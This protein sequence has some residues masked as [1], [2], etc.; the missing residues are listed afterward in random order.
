MS[1][2]REIEMRCRRSQAPALFGLVA[3]IF[4][5]AAVISWPTKGLCQ[6]A[7]G[8]SEASEA[9]AAQIPAADRNYILGPSDVLEVDVLGRADFKTRA[10]IGEDGTIQLPYLGAVV[11]AN[12]TTTQLADDISAALEKGGFFSHPILSIEIVSYASRYVTVLGEVER[13]GLIPVDR[14]YRLSEILARVGGVKDDGADYVVMRPDNGPPRHLSISALATGDPTQD[15][16]VSPGDKIFSPKAEVFYISGQVKAP[17]S[18]AVLP[19][20]TLQMAIAR[21]GGLTDQGSESK[22]K[23]SRGGR[24]RSGRIDLNE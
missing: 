14:A 8:R 23:V 13:P 2:F 18:Y 17:G 16:F 4:A 1:V 15:P 12:R 10:R 20:M 3:V 19:D 7:P 6:A 21:A 22:V 11:A 24:V 9:A 5:L